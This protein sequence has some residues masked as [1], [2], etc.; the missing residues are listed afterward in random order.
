MAKCNHL[1]A[2]ALKG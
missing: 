2:L 1:T